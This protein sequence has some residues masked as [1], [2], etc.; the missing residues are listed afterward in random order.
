MIQDNTA[1]AL[2]LARRCLF[3]VEGGGKRRGVGAPW[4]SRA[5]IRDGKRKK[6]TLSK[7]PSK[8]CEF[9]GQGERGGEKRKKRYGGRGIHL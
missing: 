4:F 8:R 7:P 6:P 5:V 3:V 1:S 9:G 2:V